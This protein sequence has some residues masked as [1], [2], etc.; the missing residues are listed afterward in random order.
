MRSVKIQKIPQRAAKAAARISAALRL[1][2]LDAQSEISNY[3]T[4]PSQSSYVR[5]GQLGQFWTVS[6]PKQRGVDFVVRVGNKKRYAG[7]VQ[8]SKQEELF[9]GFGW[10][11]ITN[12]NDKVW[13]RHRPFVVA[14]IKG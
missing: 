7:R 8:G 9:K 5:T 1:Y 10:P 11:N 13:A 14:A 4:S 6:G 3:P 12:T 2:A